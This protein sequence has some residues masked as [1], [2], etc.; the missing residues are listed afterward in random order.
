M[1]N[2][3]KFILTLI[4]GLLICVFFMQTIF[5]TKLTFI[6][7]LKLLVSIVFVIQILFLI[8]RYFFSKANRYIPMVN[9]FVSK[10]NGKEYSGHVKSIPLNRVVYIKYEISIRVAGIWWLFFGNIVKFSIDFPSEFELCDYSHCKCEYPGFEITN[11]REYDVEVSSAGTDKRELS[12]HRVMI[13][14]ATRGRVLFTAI[15]SN[16]PKKSEIIF[17]I[18]E[19]T[20]KTSF[21]IEFICGKNIH[22]AYSKTTTLEFIREANDKARLHD[23]PQNNIDINIKGT[24]TQTPI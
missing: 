4:P 8:H 24:I 12:K 21:N 2:N 20:V 19:Q 18:S 17:K 22:E 13:A 11:P 5:V 7:I 16:K 10:D 3:M 14:Q 9:I 1:G 15:A 23:F 6:Y